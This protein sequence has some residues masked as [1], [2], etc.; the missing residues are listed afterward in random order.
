VRC[1]R[2]SVWRFQVSVLS[3]IST[4]F[5]S[6]G[7]GLDCV[8]LHALL[9]GEMWWG[10]RGSMAFAAEGFEGEWWKDYLKGR[11]FYLSVVGKVA[12]VDGI[13]DEFWG[14]R[15]FLQKFESN[16]ASFYRSFDRTSRLSKETLIELRVF[17]Q[18]F[19]QALRLSAEISIKLCVFLLGFSNNWVFR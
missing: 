16:F 5:F 11:W 4:F 2:V 17:L 14:F 18:K 13:F 19:S 15:G 1:S 8:L 9:G 6:L 12:K 3:W 7:V 10:E